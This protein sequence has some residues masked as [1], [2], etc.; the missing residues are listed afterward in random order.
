MKKEQTTN[1]I[2]IPSKNLKILNKNFPHCFNKDGF[3]DFKKFKQEFSKNEDI[4]F[5]NESYGMDWLGKNYARLLA[6]DEAATLLKENID[7]NKKSENKISF[8][9]KLK[10]SRFN[11]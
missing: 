3:F 10:L 2:K 9:S 4:D 6:S 1:N 5:S 7:W 8:D 11:F